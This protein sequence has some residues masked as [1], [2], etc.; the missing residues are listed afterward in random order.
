MVASF[1]CALLKGANGAANLGQ[2]AVVGAS[3]NVQRAGGWMTRKVVGTWKNFRHD[4]SA[5]FVAD[6]VTNDARVEK[7]FRL[8][9][10]K[11]LN[12]A[13][14]AINKVET[15]LAGSLHLSLDAVGAALN[16]ITA[17]TVIATSLGGGFA[18]FYNW[19]NPLP[20]DVAVSEPAMAL[21]LGQN[22]V[23]DFNTQACFGRKNNDSCLY[24][25]NSD[26]TSE[27]VVAG[28]CCAEQCR[29][30]QDDKICE[31]ENNDVTEPWDPTYPL[32]S[33]SNQFMI[34]NGLVSKARKSFGAH[35][36]EIAPVADSR[37]GLSAS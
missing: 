29:E 17:N 20:A 30:S 34:L 28:V 25:R 26:S 24:L 16:G 22:A 23:K 4:P 5:K 6:M 13:S 33:M 7:S 31:A 19:M 32:A 12:I 14:K 2:T 36:E 15:A 3:E 1:G 8:L 11:V 9:G 27:D 21:T 35:C 10:P 37:L 18:F